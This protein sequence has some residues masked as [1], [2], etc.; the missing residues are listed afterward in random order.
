MNALDICVTFTNTSHLWHT[1]TKKF[2]L[3][4]MLVTSGPF[5]LKATSVLTKVEPHQLAQD[6][7]NLR[8]QMVF[9]TSAFD[10]V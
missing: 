6:S 1:R 9:H 7:A 3:E 4:W 2:P 10:R 8:R 5:S